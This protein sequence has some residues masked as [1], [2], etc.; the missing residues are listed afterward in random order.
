MKR[1]FKRLGIVASFSP[2]VSFA[3]VVAYNPML[4]PHEEH[5]AVYAHD[6]AV[7][8]MIICSVDRVNPCRVL[9]GNH[10]YKSGDQIDGHEIR[11]EGN[12]SVFLMGAGGTRT[13]LYLSRS[14]HHRDR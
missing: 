10:W 9:L 6:D 5:S 8:R 7:L 1:I 13:K 3:Q 4:V 2:F 12:S 11:V 14:V